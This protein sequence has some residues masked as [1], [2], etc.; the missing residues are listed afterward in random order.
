MSHM[1][2]RADIDGLRSLAVLPVVLF[3]AG[4]QGMSGGFVGVDVFFVISGFLITGILKTD[5]D[6]GR[7]SIADFYERRIRR[8]LPALTFAIVLTF[9]AA[10]FLFLPSYFVD[11]GK[12]LVATGSFIS[13]FYFWKYSGY[14]DNSALLRP[15]LH[16]WSL[17][18]EEQFYIFM[19]IAVYWVHKYLSK[20]WIAV[21]GVA[22]VLSFALSIFMTTKGPT[23]NFFLLPT[24]TWELLLGSLL[25]L[26]PLKPLPKLYNNLLSVIG[27]VLIV[28]PV[29]LYSEATPFPGLSA[30]PPCLGAAILIYV[31]TQNTS[32]MS[33]VLSWSPLVWIG[34]ISYSLYLVHWPVTVFVRY[35]TLENPNALSVLFII[36][37]S[38]ILAVFSW[39]VVEQP[40]RN[41]AFIQSRLKLFS[42][43][44]VTLLAMIG[45]GALVVQAKGLPQRFPTYQ[46]RVDTH[47]DSG[48]QEGTCF[49]EAHMPIS[50]WDADKC[51]IVKND[52]ESAMLWGDSYAAHYVP[53][54]VANAGHIPYRVYQYTSAGCPPVLTYYSYARPNC[55]AFNRN[56]LNVIKQYNIKTVI[57]SGRWIDMKGRGLGEIQ[58]TLSALDSLGVKVYVIGQSPIFVTNAD[59]IA[60]R[61]SDGKQ[62]VDRWSNSFDEALNADLKKAVG[63]H[64]FIDPVEVFCD[65]GKC[66]YR[67]DGQLLFSDN[68]HLTQAGSREAIKTYFPLYRP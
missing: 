34:K 47:A 21:F 42:V 50:K 59:V 14:F 66:P 58:S 12:S 25:A 35:Y 22:A 36:V 55:Q 45:A 37:L 7:F 29:V 10:Y 52:G 65:K 51:A 2:Y 24:R 46:P 13:N 39:W 61:K 57:L 48:W 31:G 60:F 28:V 8:I 64:S 62:A 18:V 68:G 9:V 63:T 3:H 1:K 19:P 4:V 30:L 43:A 33:Q 27:V 23:A 20:R 32:W 53:G 40:F 15:L 56:A 5:A 67:K 54:I 6:L 16:T 38:F 41:R 26:V 11:F 17:A 49:F 44:L